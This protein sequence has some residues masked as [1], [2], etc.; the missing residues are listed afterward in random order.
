MK[1]RNF[2]FDLYG[3]LVDIHT[4][5]DAP[6]LWEEMAAYYTERGAA[7]RP[8]ELR[9]A[10]LRAV[11]EAEGGV[12]LRCDAHEAHPEIRI[13]LVFQRL[14]QEKSADADLEQA[15]RAGRR[16][17]ELS[18]E[19]IRLYDGAKELLG[20][21]RKRGGVWLL[22]NA[23]RIFTAWELEHLGLT[24]FFDGIYLSSDYGVKK[25]DR[26]FFEALLR[27]RDIARPSAVMIGNDGLCDI[28]GGREAG[29]ATV[30]I[31]SNISPDEPSPD[32]DYVLEKM[33]LRRVL[34]I[35]TEGTEHM[36]REEKGLSPENI[37]AA[38]A[39]IERTLEQMLTLAKVSASDLNV[40]REALQRTLER[41]QKK[42]DRIADELEQG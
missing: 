17:R 24:P 29:L 36:E 8:E 32:A 9:R 34:E 41:L 13:E 40:D 5:E 2:I 19:Y 4:D 18:T 21:L 37:D 27:E 11:G 20:A 1:Y 25:P 16:F 6:H 31:H 3:T 39:E 38:L 28:Q 33:D 14:F 7:Y 12:S 42:I 10:Y 26:R 15:V 22:S 23:Q 30:Y 35:L